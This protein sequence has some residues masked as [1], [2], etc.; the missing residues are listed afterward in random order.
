MKVENNYGR[1]DE[2]EEKG[3]GKAEGGE[4]RM[5]GEEVGDRTGREVKT[6]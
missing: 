1:R 3:K 6:D 5:T 2:R 4:Q